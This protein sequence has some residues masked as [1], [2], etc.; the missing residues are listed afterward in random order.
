MGLNYKWANMDEILNA[1]LE[2][3][4]TGKICVLPDTTYV[5]ITRVVNLVVS[6]T[7]VD[8]VSAN[9]CP[10]PPNKAMAQVDVLKAKVATL[11]AAADAANTT[12]NN[13]KAKFTNAPT[14][15]QEAA[16]RELDIATTAYNEAQ[17]ALDAAT[18][19]LDKAMKAAS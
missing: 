13:A 17:A 19:E 18:L 11:K 12:L 6:E 2:N 7:K 5:N 10:E 1:A 4:P 14:D 15:M 16:R 8:A 3:A 9:D